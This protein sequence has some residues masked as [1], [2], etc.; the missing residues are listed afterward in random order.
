M[1]VCEFEMHLYKDLNLSE[2]SRR[3][4]F[5][6]GGWTPLFFLSLVYGFTSILKT[7]I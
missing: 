7:I 3:D 1:L 6:F 2:I 5:G 4:L